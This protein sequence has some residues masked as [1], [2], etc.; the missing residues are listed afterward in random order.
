MPR[1]V[2][3]V[4]TAVLLTPLLVYAVSDGDGGVRAAQAQE[5]E[6]SVTEAL[7]DLFRDT[8]RGSSDATAP[9]QQGA[10]QRQDGD[11]DLR[12][13]PQ[14]RAEI[15]Q[16][17]SPLVK[18]TAPAV[19][20][21]YADR[22][23]VRRSPF[24]GDPFFEQFFGR[25]LPN[26]TQKQSSLGSGVIIEKS[27]IVV[28]NNHVISGAD[29]IR[30]ALSDGRE[31][32]ST[33]MLKDE[34]FDLAVLK[35]DAGGTFPSI[36]FG[37]SD[38]LEVGDLVLAIGNP[39]GVGQTVTSGIVSALARNRIGVSDFGFFIQTDAAINPG[40]SGGALVD[41]H[42]NLIGINTAIFSRSG[43]S[44]GIGFAIPANLVRAFALSAESGS[45][46]FDP[47]YIGATF[48]SV[49]ADIAEALDLSRASGALIV[50]V[51]P[52][53]PADKAGLEPGDIITHFNGQRV[54]HPDALGYRL[55]TVAV[56]TTVE[57][58]VT[59]RSGT[60][61]RSVTLAKTPEKMRMQ[62]V[63][64]TGDNPFSGITVSPLTPE[65][66]R[67]LRLPPKLTGLVI[68]DVDSRSPAAERGF[69]RRDIL[70]EVNGE[71][72]ASAE[73]LQ[74]A[75]DAGGY[76]LRFEMIRNGRRIRQMFNR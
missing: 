74:R 6:K 10:G 16:S 24:Q 54:E 17:F 46:R 26:R 2:K 36:A 57:L 14:S 34:R 31:F 75:V 20:N 1:F 52:D 21:V 62:P 13:V 72:V 5:Q 25:S 58:S 32:E 68:T 47:P 60:V 41:M 61:T 71:V 7:G 23:V 66:L 69:R 40:N 4:L 35:I 64:I 9:A 11:G 3:A 15:T 19:V 55:A 70:T 63:A 27:G 18:Q 65:L 39:F 12:R 49:T 53:S 56:G 73:D 50:R 51:D 67:Q 8:L 42:G 38:A 29:D 37:D 43:G 76:F 44:N 59:G 22:T 30:V 48:Q 28:T 33:V 45:E